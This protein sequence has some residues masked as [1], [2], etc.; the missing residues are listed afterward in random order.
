MED[1]KR[2]LAKANSRLLLDIGEGYQPNGKY[3][4]QL[5][6]VYGVIVGLIGFIL[7]CCGEY[8]V[9][10]MLLSGHYDMVN[11]LIGILYLALVIIPPCMFFYFLA[12]IV[13]GL[14]QIAM[15][16]LSLS[17]AE[18]KTDQTTSSSNINSNQ[19][20]ERWVCT[21]CGKENLG[22]FKFCEHCGD[23][24]TYLKAVKP[25]ISSVAHDGKW[26][27]GNCQTEN[28]MNYGQCKKCGKFRG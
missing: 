12:L 27:C 21:S 4:K 24:R 1:A 8:A 11:I 3:W 13:L 17:D 16:T 19:P 7:I 18:D 25:A 23:N 6:I 22:S 10:Y 20:K 5:C 26:V 28:S 9:E 14:G 15:N 2:V